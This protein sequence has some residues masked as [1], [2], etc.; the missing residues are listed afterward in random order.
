MLLL[1]LLYLCNYTPICFIFL[2]IRRIR[3]DFTQVGASLGIT[4]QL[5]HN[6]VFSLGVKATSL[7]VTH[8]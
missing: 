4:G 1:I 8:K 7:H 2:L 6:A 3:L 5:G